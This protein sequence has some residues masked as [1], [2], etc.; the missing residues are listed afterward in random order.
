MATSNTQVTIYLPDHILEYVTEYCTE[1]GIVRKKDSKAILATGIVDL[2]N[3]L[4]N[5]PIEALADNKTVA[6]QDIESLIEKKLSD[7]KV[8]SKLLDTLLDNSDLRQRLKDSLVP[9]ENVKQCHT[10]PSN[11]PDNLPDKQED[12]V[13]EIE[14]LMALTQEDE[15]VD[16]KEKIPQFYRIK[17]ALD[18]PV[19]SIEEVAKAFECSIEQIESKENLNEAQLKVLQYVHKRD[20]G[21]YDNNT[22]EILIHKEE[23]VILNDAAA[24]QYLEVAENKSIVNEGSIEQ[25]EVELTTAQKKVMNNLKDIPSNEKFSYNALANKLGVAR[26]VLDSFELWQQEFD[27]EP[28]LS[29][30]GEIIGNIYTK[31]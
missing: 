5:I 28:K 18:R 4:V 14:D 31:M 20:D 21:N 17:N 24:N 7:S 8:L 22:Y 12:I 2:L 9:D 10:L 29:K 27:I 15:Q 13:N 11:L 26:S 30:K 3:I 6:N 25:K 23:E 19:L 16:R 1:Y